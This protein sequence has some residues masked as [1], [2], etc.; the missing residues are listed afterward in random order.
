LDKKQAI[1]FSW[2]GDTHKELG[3]YDVAK[4]NYLRAY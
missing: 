4:H 3:H 2:L 1:S